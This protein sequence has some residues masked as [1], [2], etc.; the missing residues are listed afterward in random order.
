MF[1]IGYSPK[2][3]KGIPTLIGIPFGL[4]ELAYSD[5]AVVR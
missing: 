1:G 5:Y 2:R 3:K 4:A